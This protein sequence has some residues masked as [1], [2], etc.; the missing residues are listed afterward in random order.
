[1]AAPSTLPH[2]G[3]P[4]GALVARS[5]RSVAVLVALGAC[6]LT[7]IRDPDIFWHLRAGELIWTTRS[8][9][10]L[11]PFS[12]TA[13]GEWSYME[14]AAELLFY[15]AHRASG[16]AGLSVLAAVLT[17][18]IG[19]L[20]RDLVK[21]RA[22]TALSLAAT[23]ALW[24]AASWFRFGPKTEMFSFLA[25]AA[26]LVALERAER[27]GRWRPLLA[28]PFVFLAWANTH[29]GGVLGL[30]L[31][32]I[33][34]AVW[35]LDPARRRLLRPLAVASGLAL[36]ALLV[37]P[38]GAG[39]LWS[40]VE[41]LSRSS[42][43]RHLPEWGPPQLAFFYRINPAFTI[44]LLLWL[45]DARQWRDRPRAAVIAAAAVVLA[46]LGVRFVPLAAICIA[47]SA[48]RSVD[49][50][51]EAGAK[52]L[53]RLVRRSLWSVA[54]GTA[55]FA[56]LAAHVAAV[57]PPGDWGFGVSRWRLPVG[58]AEFLKRSPP[59][60]RMWNHF[61]FGGY[62][63]FSLGP[64]QKVFI[65]GRNDTV[66][67]D[68]FFAESA[69]AASDPSALLAQVGRYRIGYVV[70]RCP[71][72][73]TPEQA[74]IFSDPGW[75]LVYMDDVAAVVVQRNDQTRA[76]LERHGYQEV[77]PVDGI[78]R[79]A[80]PGGSDSRRFRFEQEVARLVLEAPDSIRARIMAS[81]VAELRGQASAAREH[82]AV[83]AALAWQRG[84]VGP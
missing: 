9:P 48:A 36:A 59:P 28:V 82:D 50:F 51:L 70:L 18:A 77:S 8:I 43:S 53:S 31:L 67:E 60:G 7:R 73:R 3:H 64:E 63:L 83:A 40:A 74:W 21:P 55:L 34:A 2:Q 56:A 69:R 4:A 46:F 62:L 42:F 20:V 39:Y 44:M 10:H 22:Q 5:L 38:A 33:A 72:V 15:A 78:I 11:D 1:M 17:V 24:G 54:A 47:P 79:S 68:S 65:D 35:A 23:L 30:G 84:L 49:R 75:Q 14:V 29:R 81:N 57:V 76:Y 16:F 52:R 13:T 27:S 41:L 26:L 19:V 32:A 66:Y 6:C 71:D 61:N 12:H 45:A 37:N 25:C 80:A 58:A